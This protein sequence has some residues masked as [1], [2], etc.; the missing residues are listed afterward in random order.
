MKKIRI[1]GF[2]L[3]VILALAIVG[4]TTPTI[5]NGIKLGLDLKGGFEILYEAQPVVEGGTVTQESLRETAKSLEKRANAFGVAE[6]EVTTEGENRIRVRIAGVSDEQTVREMMRKPAELTFRGPD[7]TEELIGS[8]F[9]EGAADVAF[10]EMNQPMIL[11]EVK[12]KEKLRAVSE[13]LFGQPL[14]I[15][16]DETKLSEPIV[17][18]ILSD[19]KATISGDY[20][21]EEA[22]ELADVINLGALPLKL[23]E[24]YT[25]SVGASLGQQS[26]E[27]TLQAGFIASVLIL[28]FMLVIYRLPGL[29]ACITLIVYNWGLLLLFYWMQ[30]TLTLPGIA[31]FVLGIG[32]AVDAN[33]ITAERIREELRSGKTLLSSMK[34]GSKNSFRTILDANVTTIVAASVLYF[35]GTGAIQGFALTLILSN[36]LSMATNVYFSRFLLHLFIRTGLLAKP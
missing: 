31:A 4:L 6:P 5:T 20:T 19:G 21:L 12:E 7:G 23:S 33:I 16:L 18:A 26:L 14:A 32:M 24:K 34:A 15:Y 3:S 28:L 30:A 27:Q 17:R 36:V 1:A 29:I 10:D 2:F 11:V 9:V 25:Q 22:N 8:D 35:V 13:K